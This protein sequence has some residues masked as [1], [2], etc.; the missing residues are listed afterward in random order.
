MSV[1]DPKLC[2]ALMQYGVQTR[3][4]VNFVGSFLCNGPIYTFDSNYLKNVSLDCFSYITLN[5]HLVNTKIGRYCSIASYI[6]S[7]TKQY[8]LSSPVLSELFSLNTPLFAV[9]GYT[10]DSMHLNMVTAEHGCNTA[11]QSYESQVEI[12]HDVWVGAKVTLVGDLKIGHGSVIGA[13]AVITKD[14]PPYAIVVGNDRLVHQRFS[15]EVVADLLECNW[16]NYN[17]PAMIQNG[18]NLDYEDPRA[19][20]KVLRDLDPDKLIDIPQ[21]WLKI[22][23]PEQEPPLQQLSAKKITAQEVE[24]FFRS[25]RRYSL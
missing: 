12:G 13:G 9:A 3:S 6:R 14:V 10:P 11:N 17:L 15:D 4:H 1:L 7:G 2:Q 20:V 18:L 5:N 25:L 16:W 23:F 19:V 8:D 22:D 24:L 21:G